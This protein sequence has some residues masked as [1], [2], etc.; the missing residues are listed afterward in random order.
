VKASLGDKGA[1]AMSFK[2]V[3]EHLYDWA[4][5]ADLSDGEYNFTMPEP[6]T[7][8]HEVAREAMHDLLDALQRMGL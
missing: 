2:C 6:G 5:A 1:P 4:N 8:R 3:L 7:T